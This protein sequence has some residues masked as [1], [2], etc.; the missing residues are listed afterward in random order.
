MPTD[1]LFPLQW[2]LLN[3]GNINGS[4]AGYDINVVR[5]WPDYTGKGVVMGVMD[6][7]F[8]E[9]HPMSLRPVSTH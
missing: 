9:T 1:P 8:D 6:S 7:G 3:T 5:V 2:H 4:I